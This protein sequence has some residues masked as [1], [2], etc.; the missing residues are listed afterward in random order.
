MDP[1]VA[2]DHALEAARAAGA[3]LARVRPAEIR[4]KSSPTDLVT[5]WDARAEALLAETL[6]RRAPGVPIL[7]EEEGLHG[8][9]GGARWIVDPIDGTVN[10]AHGLPLFSVSIAYEEAGRLLAGV[11]LAP[12]LGWE[13]A[14]ARGQGA[15]LNGEPMR[16]SGVVRLEEAMLSTGFPYDVA[17]TFGN[18]AEWAWFVRRAGAV[19]RLGSAALDLALV[20]RG[21]FDGHWE[22]DLHAWDLGAGALLVEEAGG[23]VTSPSGGPVDIDSGAIVASNGLVHEA[24]LAGLR[25]AA[26]P[27]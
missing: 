8:A 14:A 17:T 6:A 4:A 1:A 26:A 11:V 24:I 19:R 27:P 16:V 20:A 25:A 23:R 15:T 2:R 9:A 12:L 10:F 22:R 21:W 18:L 3:V 7:G 13:F 5:E